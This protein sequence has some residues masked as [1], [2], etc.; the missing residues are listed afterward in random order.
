MDAKKADADDLAS[1][2]GHEVTTPAQYMK[3]V[4]L[5]PRVPLATRL[6]AAKAAAPYTDRKQPMALDGG[7]NTDGTPRPIQLEMTD[8]MI[9]AL[10]PEE[11][12]VLKK[13]LAVLRPQEAA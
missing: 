12:S 7:L 4:A 11:R 13:A 1:V 2:V 9:A 6:E 10:T 3:A 8:A 5:D